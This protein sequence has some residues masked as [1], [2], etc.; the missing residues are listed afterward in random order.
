MLDKLPVRGAVARMDDTVS[1]ALARAQLPDCVKNFVAQMACATALIA[2]RMAFDGT[3]ILQ[4]KGDGPLA[5]AIAEVGPDLSVRATA[6]LT[7]DAVFTGGET[8]QELVNA[9]GKGLCALFADSRTRRDGE[10]LYESVVA[11]EG[12]DIS[13]ALTG[14]LLQTNQVPTYLKVVGDASH[15]GGIY[16]E[17][18]PTE[19]GRKDGFIDDPDAFNRASKFAQTLTAEELK[20]LEP[21]EII[22]R[23]FWE[24]D[25]R[26][27]DPVRPRFLCR[28][29][30]QRFENIIRMLGREEVDSIIRQ[31]GKFSIR[32]QFCGREETFSKEEIQAVF[33]NKKPTVN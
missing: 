27:F 11:L 29:S 21:L 5:L 23:L 4:I 19:G 3:L 9:H 22:H 24:D 30:R 15:A 13:E 8:F 25:V 32:C 1:E 16:L 14:F 33:D 20:G 31:E 7:Q 12:E 6:S 28:C 26:V 2:Q 18:M 10:P 17:E